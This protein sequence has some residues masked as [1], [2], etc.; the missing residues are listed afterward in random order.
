VARSSAGGA[1]GGGR[2][3]RR[4]VRRTGL[5]AVRT[6]GALAVLLLVLYAVAP[7]SVFP[8]IVR[9][10][11][12]PL[13]E[14]VLGSA[15]HVE[16]VETGYLGDVRLIGVALD[17]PRGTGVLLR[18][19]RVS[20]RLDPVSLLR[21]RLHFAYLA[22]D[23]AN[24]G[25]RRLPDG[26]TNVDRAIAGLLGR[27]AERLARGDEDEPDSADQVLRS[28]VR[29]NRLTVS[30]SRVTVTDPAENQMAELADLDLA[31]SVDAEGGRTALAGA[32]RV[33]DDHTRQ[34]NGVRPQRKAIQGTDPI[35]LAFDVWATAPGRDR[36]WLRTRLRWSGDA[37]P[38]GSRG[39]ASGAP[40]GGLWVAPLIAGGTS[41]DVTVSLGRRLQT[42]VLGRVEIRA[43]ALA[44][45]DRSLPA[46]TVAWVELAPDVTF[47][48]RT[49][50]STLTGRVAAAW[51]DMRL[52]A[53]ELG[54]DVR[55]LAD[56]LRGASA[57][58]SGNAECRIEN[59]RLATTA[60]AA[61]LSNVRLG[62]TD[63]GLG[64]AAAEWN[65]EFGTTDQAKGGAARPPMGAVV[66]RVGIRVEDA[67]VR[68]VL[69]ALGPSFG[70]QSPRATGRLEYAGSLAFEHDGAVRAAGTGRIDELRLGDQSPSRP[71]GA[72]SFDHALRLDRSASGL[73]V[74][75]SSPGT[76]N[77]RLVSVPLASVLAEV[78]RLWPGSL[79]GTPPLDGRFDGWSSL[80]LESDT[81]GRRMVVRA[82]GTFDEARVRAAA[83]SVP[84]RP[85][86]ARCDLVLRPLEGTVRGT[87]D[88]AFPPVAVAP[89]LNGLGAPDVARRLDGACELRA[90]LDLGRD[91]LI[92]GDLMSS[93]LAV[94]TG[95]G[96]R[97]V[98]D[99]LHLASEVAVEAGGRRLVLKPTTLAARGAHLSLSG[100]AERGPTGWQGGLAAAANVRTDEALAALRT[101]GVGLP[102]D[103]ET[104]GVV[105]LNLNL[106]LKDEVVR[107]QGAARPG[108]AGPVFLGRLLRLTKA[109]P[110]EL[111]F[112]LD[113]DRVADVTRI[114]RFAFSAPGVSGSLS[115]LLD[116]ARDT[117]D[118]RV[119]VRV[120]DLSQARKLCPAAGP[121][122]VRGAAAL[123][124]QLT[125]RLGAPRLAA[126]VR[127]D[128]VSAPTRP[129]SPDRARLRGAVDIVGP[130]P[131]AWRFG[132]DDLVVSWPDGEVSVSGRGEALPGRRATAAVRVTGRRILVPPPERLMGLPPRPAWVDFLQAVDLDAALALDRLEIG[133]LDFDK[134]TMLARVEAGRVTIGPAACLLAGGGVTVSGTMDAADTAPAFH[135]EVR[136]A[137]L[138]AEGCLAEMLRKQ[139]PSL[140][141]QGAGEVS[142]QVTVAVVPPAARPW[143]TGR[144][145]A[146]WQEGQFVGE[147][148]PDWLSR[149]FRGLRLDR[150]AFQT[151]AIDALLAEGNQADLSAFCRAPGSADLAVQV[152][153]TSAGTVNI[154][155]GV[156]LLSSVN[157][158]PALFERNRPYVVPIYERQEAWFD[159]RRIQSAGGFRNPVDVSVDVLVRRNALV[160]ELGKAGQAGLQALELFLPL[161]AIQEL[162]GG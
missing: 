60:G 149:L 147:T 108:E 16:R 63:I 23:E 31:G 153:A 52:D 57:V 6:C 152:L 143:P 98:L 78:E 80:A 85:V 33:L 28:V 109:T 1:G 162:A 53:R 102:P 90:H 139:V 67:P 72:V 25:V 116:V 132:S 94:A 34:E 161:R 5:A 113:H 140:R 150:Y 159:G 68:D 100:E 127:L 18:A 126:T 59:G 111:R 124:G 48:A 8:W 12:L 119:Q 142:G 103:I 36:Q 43:A 136:A 97:V 41:G 106:A 4:L 51:R 101:A 19:S 79:G 69:T 146:V 21:G 91:L 77:A 29:I 9:R 144:L 137:G 49:P 145:R 155:A 151:V 88:G 38:S 128:G 55:G 13:L 138:R 3:S 96:G 104:G 61:A 89:V 75:A 40:M 123:T 14:Q 30:Q 46:A 74:P 133:P 71:A 118:V 158:T 26:A 122:D 27:M 58:V 24:L 87:I 148:S 86:E 154:Q 134:V 64:L 129:G 125:G 15:L 82:A 95:A 62:P 117:A 135:L 76:I 160:R 20:G 107:L 10:V 50:E 105:P 39:A 47:S 22:V 42:S 141:L 114:E 131:A 66:G 112:T 56:L 120:S 83:V 44:P 7:F 93:R 35:F 81:A 130:A 37:P 157:P 32:T 156:D 2:R 99:N 121:G 17:D 92:D 65:L 115:G 11:A 45:A 84:G 54:A 73:R 70:G 110:A